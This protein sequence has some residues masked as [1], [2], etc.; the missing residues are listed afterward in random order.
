[1]FAGIA[2]VRKSASAARR[3][4]SK[5]VKICMHISKKTF[6]RVLND[7]FGRNGET[8]IKMLVLSN[9]VWLFQ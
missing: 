5:P 8:S 1:M 7:S 2:K 6:S 9:V 4:V 3:H